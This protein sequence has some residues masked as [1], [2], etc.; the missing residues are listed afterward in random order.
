MDY[1]NLRGGEYR[2]VMRLE[3]ENTNGSNELSVLIRK[4]LVIHE[5]AWFWITVGIIVLLLNLWLIRLM[6][7]RQAR[8]IER[9]KDQERIAGDLRLASD[10]QVSALPR[11]LPQAA[12]GK[13]FDL[14]ASMTPAKEVGGDFYDYFL[15]DDDHLAMVIADVSGKGIPAALFMTVSKAL[16]KTQL[17]TGLTPAEAL[18]NVNLQLCENNESKMFVTVWAAVIELSTGK[19]LACNAGHEHPALRRA[20]G[21]FELQKY[22]HNIFTGA[23]KKAK[24]QNREFEMRPGDCLFVYTDGIP[25]AQNA[26]EELFGEERLTAALNRE[27]KAGPEELMSVV[28]EAVDDFVQDAPQFDDLTMLSFRYWGAETT[29]TGGK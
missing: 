22:K 6:L 25:E 1:T 14:H 19:G 27:P 12:E 28:R 20:G 4:E 18:T 8:R 21:K 24:Y 29:V 11:A 16:I 13:K 10:I 2:F 26:Q 23:S 5:Q 7:K 3:G 17:M 15:I 9:K